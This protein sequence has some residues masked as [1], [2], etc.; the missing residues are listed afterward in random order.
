[1]ANAM[2]SGKEKYVTLK[3][4]VPVFIGYFTSWVDQNGKLNFRDD[5]YG[6]DKEI[7]EHLFAKAIV[8]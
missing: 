2:N 7:A 6:H 8:K 5:L 4:P 1:M 3:G